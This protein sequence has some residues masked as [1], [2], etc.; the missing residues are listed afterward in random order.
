MQPNP[1]V[2]MAAGYQELISITAKPKGDHGT[3]TGVCSRTAQPTALCP[4][5][6]LQMVGA[7]PKTG[8]S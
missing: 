8:R 4:T 5:T 3:G 6:S 1:A 2:R 7:V